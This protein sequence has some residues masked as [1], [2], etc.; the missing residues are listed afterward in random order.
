MMKLV[1]Q[2][3]LSKTVSPQLFSSLVEIAAGCLGLIC[4]A[5]A[6]RARQ[7]PLSGD[8]FR[9]DPFAN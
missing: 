9:H 6:L 4:L 8:G 7:L 2:S 5:W 3:F 1:S